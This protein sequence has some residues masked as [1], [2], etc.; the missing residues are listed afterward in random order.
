MQETV[1]PNEKHQI[2]PVT[3]EELPAFCDL[4]REY[5]TWLGDSG[6]KPRF[7]NTLEGLRKALFEDD[8]PLFEAIMAYYDGQPAGLICWSA[9]YHIMSG[10]TTMEI[11]HLYLRQS[12]RQQS[13]ALSL[14]SYV[15]K[16]ADSRGYWRV[17][18]E[19]GG[20]NKPVQTLF[21]L[22]NAQRIDHIRFR[23]TG[24]P[25]FTRK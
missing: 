19:V 1:S 11:K 9:A 14:M 5:A 18:G 6:G 25:A 4:M 12:V 22:L 17:E 21:S 10:E 13:L 3:P 2:V 23:I 15:L 20:W 24:Q 7:M 8:P 16:L